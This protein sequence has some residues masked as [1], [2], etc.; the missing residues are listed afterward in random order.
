M[1]TQPE[2]FE[3]SLELDAEPLSRPLVTEGCGSAVTPPDSAPA[4]PDV[5]PTVI[6]TENSREFFTLCERAEAGEL[7]IESVAVGKTNAQW[8]FVVRWPA[9]KLRTTG[10]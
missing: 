5:R 6:V 1:S 2:L 10:E 9:D 3:T 7:Q 8:V 4:P